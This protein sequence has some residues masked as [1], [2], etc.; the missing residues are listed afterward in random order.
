M[1]HRREFLRTSAAA[2]AAALAA[3]TLALTGSESADVAEAARQATTGPLVVDGTNVSAL[4]DDYIDQMRTAGVDVWVHNRVSTEPTGMPF[5]ERVLEYVDR[6]RN[7]LTIA[8]TVTEI[9]KAKAAGKVAMV[10]GWQAATP[11]EGPLSG[12]GRKP[13]PLELR[14]LYQ[15]GLRSCGITYNISNRFGGGCMDEW[16]GLTAAGRYI[17][18]RFHDMGIIVD[19]GGHTG[20]RASLDVIEMSRGV[21]VICSH[22]NCRAL[23]DNPRNVTDRVIEGIAS[24]SGVVGLTA[25]NDFLARSR[26]DTHIRTSPRVGLDVLLD[27]YDHVKRLVGADHVGIGTDFTAGFPGTD[28]YLGSFTAP[29]SVY[30]AQEDA[31]VYVRGFE[32]IGELPNL[33]DG[34]RRRGWTRE[35]VDKAMGGNWIR[36]FQRVWGA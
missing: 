17:V 5:F 4:T 20:E 35:E 22:T 13:P 28:P 32:R 27:H 9:R 12:W 2:G 21:P 3:P 11:L 7:R 1:I 29:P 25:L 6:N 8:T 34:L 26:H 10:L 19:V 15:L 14:T 23:M 16:I 30:S 18:E 31:W 24:T 36:V 33:Q